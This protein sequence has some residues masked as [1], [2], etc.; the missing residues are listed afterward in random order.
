MKSLDLLD[1]SFVVA[2]LNRSD[3]HHHWAKSLWTELKPP[4]LTCE[5]VCAETMHLMRNC[6][7]G[8]R[9]LLELISRGIVVIRFQAGEHA[10]ALKLLMQKYADLPMSF[11]DAC[12]VR[13]AELE[14]NSRVFTA[15]SDFTIYRRHGR[16]RIITELPRT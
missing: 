13:M 6:S 3:A 16:Q 11:A 1:T 2:L 5:A 9:E 8:G 7:G 12:L 10:A 4:V 14:P 15:D